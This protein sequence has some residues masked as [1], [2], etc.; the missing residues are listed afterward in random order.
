MPPGPRS[1]IPSASGR[2][3]ARSIIGNWVSQARWRIYL[4]FFLLFI[5]IAVFT[6]SVGRL[7]RRQAEDH[8]I[9]ESTQLARGGLALVEED[10]QED[11]QFLQAMADRPSFA[12]AWVK[13]DQAAVERQLQEAR[14][15]SADFNAV[16]AYSLDG[17]LRAV[18]PAQ[19]GLFGRNFTHRDWYRGV[20]REWK[21]Y[22]SGM[23]QTSL[24]NELGVAIALP[25]ADR[26]KKP[27]GILVAVCPANSIGRELVQAQSQDNWI[28]SVVDQYGRVASRY[29]IDPKAPAPDLSSYEPVKRI[30]AGISGFG[31]FHR[32]GRGYA[33]GYQPVPP[34][35]WGILVEQPESVLHDSVGS[36]EKQVWILAVVLLGVGLM[37]SAFIGSLYS[38]LETGN[39]FVNLSADLFCI[40]SY[41][42]RFKKINPSWERTLGF[43][44]DELLAQ[45]YEALMHPDDRDASLAEISRIEA[46]GT[47]CFAFEN[48]FRCKDGTYKWLSWNA[49][50]VPEQRLTY[51]VAR[52]ITE[53]KRV[54]T[55]LRENE[56]LFHLMISGVKDYAIFMLDAAGRVASWNEGAERIKGYKADEIVGRHFSCFYPAKDIQSGKPEHELKIAI[57]EGRYEEE[58]WR[59]RKDGSS[60]WANV[61]I[62]ALIDKRGM[63]RG[64]SKV[65]RDITERRRTAEALEKSRE[66]LLTL[67]EVAPDPVV[68]VDERGVI[69][70]V[71]A[72]TEKVFGY[73]RDE[74]LGQSVEKLVPERSRGNH[75]QHRI[76]YVAEPHA[77]P[78]GAG[79]ELN[80]RRKDGSEIP[81]EISLSP[82]Q[83]SE[84][85]R[86]ISSIRDVSERKKILRQMEQQNRELEL[87]NREVERATQLK[88][89]FLA[90]MSHE[91][92][93]PLNAVVGF[94]DLLADGTAGDL[95]EKQ[96]RFVN[97]I[98]MGSIHLLQLIN[99]ILDLSKIEAGQLEFHP[100]DILI[101][102]ALPEVLSTIRPLAMAKNIK[103]EQQDGPDYTIHADRVRFKQILYNLLSNAV[104][105]TAK[106]GH[107]E[108]S[109]KADGNQVGVSV[110]DN[111]S[112][113]PVEEQQA[114][115][116]EFRQAEGNKNG[117]QEG[118]GLG[119]AITK[120]LVEHQGG[121][122]SVRSA[123]GEGSCFSFTLPA[124]SGGQRT[125]PSSSIVV[126]PAVTAVGPN[127][128][129]IL[130]VDDEASARELLTSYLDADYRVA[131]AESG[132]AA[133]QKAKQLRPDAITLDVL[134]AG[135]SGFETLVTLRRTAETAQ[136][137]IIIVSIVDRKDMGFA[138]GATD[139][140][141]KPIRKSM[142]LESI[143]KHLP[144][145]FDEDS[146]LLLVDDDPKTLELL[147]ETLRSAG[148][149]VQSV[150]SGA[151]ALEVLS[152]KLVGAVLL[153]LLMPG[154]DGF[155]VINH[156]RQQPTLKHL[157]VFIMTAKT[158][159][160]EEI[161]RLGRDTQALFQKTGPWHQQLLD[162]IGR[163]LRTLQQAKAAGAL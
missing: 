4:L 18:Y 27:V 96:K 154:M 117:N 48:R 118:T 99:D 6:Y 43:T 23:Y 97:H 127:K 60:F 92:R 65:T 72:Q 149:E 91:L 76:G 123:P 12:E 63:L 39:R 150:R 136:I 107:V 122:I 124:A 121:R 84:G 53:R 16:A 125:K 98:K 57:A 52:D 61:I 10:F 86:V 32:D 28:I 119:L 36:V 71:N 101:S 88:S 13:G 126:S 104:K 83:T 55:V 128:P 139:Y 64:F 44:A 15:Q 110:T 35:G 75:T 102:D 112:G 77:R 49:V 20:S 50:S 158:L 69:V 59:L 100:E 108:I 73:R 46:P 142:L 137:P 145:R 26:A 133:I 162:E 95:N 90:T 30:H 105:F 115:F 160:A 31:M 111:G 156:I 161:A 54:E 94:S 103:I 47:S 14:A 62:T 21:P 70:M 116:E 151:R 80:A 11:I 22:V 141:I 140:I 68:T 56:E 130:V 67:L 153:D 7:L 147:E 25:I 33:V 78:M 51:G 152:S 19:P 1:D 143:Y 157:P 135:S 148:Y 155:E 163:V 17:T 5:P 45:P 34:Y 42:R 9:S 114:I 40:G 132:E 81:V 109:C 2:M 113:I 134:M 93:T 24:S 159:T 41:D 82:I 131:T 87:R 89:K 144:P 37:M 138:L 129:L 85:F 66:N 38:D 106:D 79:M 8:A 3:S 58:G 146:A 120:R 29:N 74:L